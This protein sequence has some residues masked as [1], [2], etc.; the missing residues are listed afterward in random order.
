MFCICSFNQYKLHATHIPCCVFRTHKTLTLNS[1][2]KGLRKVTQTRIVLPDQ[3]AKRTKEI[4]LSP[5]LR[6]HLKPVVFI[7]GKMY[8][9]AIFA[10]YVFLALLFYNLEKIEAKCPSSSA[11]K[12]CRQGPAICPACIDVSWLVRPP[13]SFQGENVTEGVLPGNLKHFLNGDQVLLSILN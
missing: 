12:T 3:A 10:C 4:S 13:F 2:P 1:H 8:R 7:K 5:G 11:S 9:F 6:N